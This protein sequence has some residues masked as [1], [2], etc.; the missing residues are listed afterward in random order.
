MLKGKER[1]MVLDYLYQ[2]CIA[3]SRDSSA[4]RKKLTCKIESQLRYEHISHKERVE[5]YRKIINKKIIEYLIHNI[6]NSLTMEWVN[7]SPTKRDMRI[8]EWAQNKYKG[9]SKAEK[10]AICEMIGYT[11][12]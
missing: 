9:M 3:N 11:Y 8:E 1:Q 12:I 6:S 2:E 5:I 7:G 10:V 4:V